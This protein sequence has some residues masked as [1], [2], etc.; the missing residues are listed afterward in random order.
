L[1]AGYKPCNNSSACSIDRCI[2]AINSSLDVKQRCRRSKNPKVNK[3]KINWIPFRRFE[4]FDVSIFSA[5]ALN[6]GASNRFQP[7][8]GPGM[9]KVDLHV[10]ALPFYLRVVTSTAFTLAPILLLYT[11]S[12]FLLG[13]QNTHSGRSHS[14]KF[15]SLLGTNTLF[16]TSIRNELL[17]SE[18]VGYINYPIH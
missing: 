9:S 4:A 7:H 1:N 13:G 3:I 2:R 18:Y 17:L 6:G 15:W 16:R 10:S 8:S 12:Y 14:F 11:L 5:S